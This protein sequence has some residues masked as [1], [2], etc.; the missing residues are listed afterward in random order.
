VLST[1]VTVLLILTASTLSAQ[2]D[3]SAAL[4]IRPGARVRVVTQSRERVTGHLVA[5]TSDLLVVDVAGRER[6]LL[7]SEVRRL[8]TIHGVKRSAVKGL[9]IGGAAGVS[10]A[11]ATAETN[12][13]SWAAMLGAGWAAIGAVIGSVTGLLDRERLVYSSAGP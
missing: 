4:A 6:R 13:G 9:L 12:R 2:T 7:P 3:W 11:L 5:V 8:Y 1:L 10:M